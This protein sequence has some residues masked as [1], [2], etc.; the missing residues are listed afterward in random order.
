MWSD[1][2]CGAAERRNNP[3]SSFIM[4]LPSKDRMTVGLTH[5]GIDISSSKDESHLLKLSFSSTDEHTFTL[6]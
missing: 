6:E 4:R 3:G 2:S 1:H 5:K